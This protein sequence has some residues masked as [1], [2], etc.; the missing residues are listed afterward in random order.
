M[1]LFN[2]LAHMYM[3]H[4]KSPLFYIVE[5]D[6]VSLGIESGSYS[7]SGLTTKRI[8]ISSNNYYYYYASNARL[9][10]PSAWM[11]RPRYTV[12]GQYLEVSQSAKNESTSLVILKPLMPV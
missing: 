2:N 4:T 7:L 5:E 3:S 8:E 1:L 6:M 9:H 11:P 12:P 10:G